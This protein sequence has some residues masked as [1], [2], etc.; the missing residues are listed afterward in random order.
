M[1]QKSGK[2]FSFNEEKNSRS[3]LKQGKKELIDPP[4]EEK[5]EISWLDVMDKRLY[6]EH[7]IILEAHK[8]HP[9]AH[10]TSDQLSH[11]LF[12]YDYK[13]SSTHRK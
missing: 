6:I 12:A 2:L 3:T 4:K 9:F 13:N 7:D 1:L 5:L 8:R 11:D 10:P